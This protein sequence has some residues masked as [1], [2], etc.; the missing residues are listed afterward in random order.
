MIKFNLNNNLFISNI[1]LIFFLI[2]IIIPLQLMVSNI[3]E[4]PEVID[5]Y[6][7]IVYMTNVILIFTIIYFILNKFIS[8]FNK[9]YLIYISSFVLVWIILNGVLL[10]SIGGNIDFWTQ[11]TS[12]F[13]LRYILGFKFIISLFITTIILNIALLKNNFL[14][15]VSYYLFITVIINIYLFSNHFLFLNKSSKIDLNKLNIG[16][17]NIL[18]ISFDGVNGNIISDLIS[19]DK[20]KE[21]FKDFDLY[22]N[23]TVSFPAS[24]LSISSELTNKSNLATITNQDLIINQ[25]E[26]N[27]ENIYTYG[28]YN[29][30]FLG[31]NKIFEGQYFQNIN[32]FKLNAFVQTVLFP[33]ISRWATIKTYDFYNNFIRNTNYYNFTIK[34]LSFDLFNKNQILFND[35]Y[36]ISSPEVSEIFNKKNYSNIATNNAYFFHFS[37]SHWHILF[38]ENC[39]YVPLYDSKGSVNHLQN[40]KGNVQN[41]KCVIK[42][43]KSIIKS[44][45]ESN[46]YNEN[47]II[48]K[49]DHGKP[50]GYHKS[51]VY[52]QGINENIRWSIGRYNSF[53]MIKEKNKTSQEIKIIQKSVGSKFLYNFYCQNLPFE[54]KCK[55][56]FEDTVFVPIKKT[57]FHNINEFKQLNLDQFLSLDF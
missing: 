41:T 54:V 46:I 31:K 28:L 29:K 38:D 25:N 50:K 22:S 32:S 16:T 45:Q 34:L 43:I 57:T 26:N 19:A 47:I 3:N 14:K 36:R 30:I 53:F 11:Y 20:N 17:N 2:S 51:D 9:K 8:F 12:S 10:P 6:I 13:R 4:I 52:N 49:S 42:K 5:V 40:Y 27:L 1:I 15:F 24:I 48:F 21:I 18:T 44:F 7:L 37:F 33:S 39:N 56:N 55:T 35:F 23:Y